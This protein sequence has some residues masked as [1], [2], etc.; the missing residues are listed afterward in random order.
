MTIRYAIIVVSEVDSNDGWVKKGRSLAYTLP[1]THKLLAESQTA[2]L[3]Q[4]YSTQWP[5]VRV[6]CEKYVVENGLQY[7]RYNIGEDEG[8][9]KKAD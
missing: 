1:E 7:D 6:V 4:S 2:M 8:D 5:G 3:N 9:V